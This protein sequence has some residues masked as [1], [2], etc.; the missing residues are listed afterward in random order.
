MIQDDAVPEAYGEIC[1]RCGEIEEDRRTLYTACFYELN[2]LG[3]PFS[4]Q[5]LFH[6][7]LEDLE[8]A[9]PPDEIL[10]SDSKVF[11]LTYGT[12]TCKGELEPTKFYTLR[13]CKHCRADW[14]QSMVQWFRAPVTRSEP[15]EW[16]CVPVRENGVTVYITEAE[17]HNRRANV[18]KRF[19]NGTP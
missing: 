8:P 6:A 3:L 15:D 5:I 14:M 1:Q 7:K 2:E 10:L 12:V 4:Y 13:I 16:R 19:D 11:R 9:K 17:W 18:G